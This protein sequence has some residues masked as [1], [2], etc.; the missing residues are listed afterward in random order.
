MGIISLIKPLKKYEDYVYRANTYES[1]F[2][3][4]KAIETMNAAIKQPFTKEEKSS[5]LIYLGILY[6]KIKEYSKASECYNQG[7]EIM[8]DENFKYSSN[9]NKAIETF[10]KNQET[11]RAEFWLNNLLQ[12]E[13]YDKKFKKLTVLKRKIQ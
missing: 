10:I 4:N 13:D 3:R 12:R 7:L 11:E 6:S 9:F 5:G 1:L 8:K 2:L